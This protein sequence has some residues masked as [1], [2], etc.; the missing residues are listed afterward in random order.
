VR[1]RVLV[2]QPAPRAAEGAQP[3][4]RRAPAGRRG[5]RPEDAP[6]GDRAVEF[7]AGGG[8]VRGA[9]G[10]PSGRFRTALTLR[11]GATIIRRAPI[12][13]DGRSS[14]DVSPDVM[15]RAIILD[16]D[17]TLTDFMKMKGAA[18]DAALDGM[19]DAGL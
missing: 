2:H 1:A 10:P 15:I 8:L 5:R 19:V 17:N 6:A 14:P 3:G 13:A 12:S 9:E 16:L 4:R 11:A 7:P 18:I